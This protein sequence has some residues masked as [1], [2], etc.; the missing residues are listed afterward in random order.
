M[1]GAVGMSNPYYT[2]SITNTNYQ[3]QVTGKTAT[4][5]ASK[6]QPE[7]CQ[8]CKN[9]K[10]KDG[11]DEMVS[12][13]SPGHISPEESY[14][15]VMGHEQEHVSNAV[16]E[17]RKEN[18]ELVSVSVSLQTAICPECGDSY[19]SGGTTST[20]MKTYKDDPYSQ[21]RKSYEQEAMKG[22]HIDYV[23]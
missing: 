14:S 16:A 11:S 20:V 9:R 10:Y 18:K 7:E 3:S 6:V 8:T 1:I 21:N 2:G 22:N 15:K 5:D 19:V 23:A 12:F 13:K 17:G 4:E